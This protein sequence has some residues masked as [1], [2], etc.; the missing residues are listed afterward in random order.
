MLR[1]LVNSLYKLLDKTVTFKIVHLNDFAQ[2]PTK[3]DSGCAGYDIY[4]TET[5]VIKKNERRLVST[6]IS[7]E[8]PNYHYIRVAPRSGLSCKGIDIGAG[9]VDSSYRG[10][11][12]VLMINNSDD[13]Y[14][15]AMND[16]I[17]QLVME[18]CSNPTIQVCAFLSNSSRGD[19]G[20]GSTGN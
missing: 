9:V 14:F 16:R 18:R 17:A 12:K 13:D 6:G 4:S 15:V 10:E 8:V 11:I 20:F 3:A 19:R 1:T 2:T 7:V 5:I